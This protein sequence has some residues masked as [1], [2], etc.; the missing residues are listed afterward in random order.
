MLA[1]GLA[2]LALGITIRVADLRM[3]PVL[4]NSMRPTFAAWDLVVT[5]AVAT[6][7]IR[8]G[9]VITFLPPGSTQAL[10]HRVSSLRDGVITTRGDAN[11]VDDPWQVTLQGPTSYRLVA[12]VPF[13]GWLTDLQR[14]ALLLAGLLLG[15]AFALQLW[16]GVKTRLTKVQPQSQA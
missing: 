4:S 11:A 3:A 12:V 9:D 5:Q 8:V 15:L 7:A 10:I 2:I 1:A 13:V 6:S 14:P 16:K